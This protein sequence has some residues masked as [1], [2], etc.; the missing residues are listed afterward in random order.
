MTPEITEALVA[1]HDALEQFHGRSPAVARQQVGVAQNAPAC[2]TLA[3]VRQDGSVVTFQ[4][5]VFAYEEHG[6]AKAAAKSLRI[7]KNRLC[8]ILNDGGH[9]MRRLT[10]TQAVRD[11][12][13]TYYTDTPETDFDLDELAAELSRHKANVS[14]IARDM[15]LTHRRPMRA[16]SRAAIGLASAERIA[17]D[18]HPRGMLGRK[19]SPDALAKV[20]AASLAS[21]AKQRAAGVGVHSAEGKQAASDRMS[22]MRAAMP[23]ENTYSRCK[24]GRREDI[25]PMYFRSAWEANYARYLNWLKARGEIE[26]WQ[27]EPTTFWFEAIK[28]GVRSYKPDFLIFEKATSYFVEVKGWMDAKSAT[29]LK[30]MKKYHPTVEVRLF[31]AKDYASL[32]TKLSR[33]IP[34]WE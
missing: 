12:I 3:Y 18:G 10:V 1:D 15:G 24:G 14:R 25:G 31:G 19:L 2:T 32:K 21:H 33:V 30:R 6:E 16:D 20:S 34:G 5:A 4:E 7:C 13:H 9:K 11:R 29:K 8:K 22:K 28:R 23:A 17:R 27:Y 26:D